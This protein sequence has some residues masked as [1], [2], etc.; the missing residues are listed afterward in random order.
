ML[1]KFI[2]DDITGFMIKPSDNGKIMEYSIPYFKEIGV[3]DPQ[4]LSTF[5]V[6]K[7]FD[8]N[9]NI[10]NY[11]CFVNSWTLFISMDEIDP[12][13]DIVQLFNDVK[14]HEKAKEFGFETTILAE[15]AAA[16]V[17]EFNLGNRKK[18]EDILKKHRGLNARLNGVYPILYGNVTKQTANYLN[19]IQRI[20]FRHM[21]L[22]LIDSNKESEDNNIDCY[23]ISVSGTWVR[24]KNNTEE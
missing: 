5:G 8:L 21:L 16:T 1:Q 15:G 13:C 22:K 7:Y 6:I 10:Q 23:N 2:I 11:T 20:G 19:V 18:M 24:L 4:F 17:V 9:R 3:Y 14:T 12:M